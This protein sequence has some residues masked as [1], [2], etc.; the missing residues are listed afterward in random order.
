MKKEFIALAVL[1]LVFAS[2][3]VN[4]HT[5]NRLTEEVVTLIEEAEGFVR[6][7]S[8][9]DA[10]ATANVALQKWESSGAYTHTVIRHSDI[11]SATDTISSLIKEIYAED[12]G[13]AIGAAKAATL[14]MRSLASSEQLKLRN[15]L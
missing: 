6:E 4:I 3:L 9:E 13:S 5:I 11:D 2:A 8:W 10:L 12:S 14:R 1:L 15:I 7:E